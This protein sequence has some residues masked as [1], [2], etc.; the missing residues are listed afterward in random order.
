MDMHLAVI[1]NPDPTLL[2][3]SFKAIFLYK[4]RYLNRP[5]IFTATLI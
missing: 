1:V 4:A 3:A 2:Q 5:V